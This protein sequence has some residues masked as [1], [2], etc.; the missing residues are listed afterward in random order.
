MT[1]LP[2]PELKRAMNNIPREALLAFTVRL[3]RYRKE[4]KELLSYLL[5][6]ADDQPGYISN[7]K[8]EIERGFLDLN[9]A[10]PY[11]ALKGIRKVMA[12]TNQRIRFS[13]QKRTEAELLICFCTNLKPMVLSRSNNSIS[14]IYKR[15]MIRIKRTI[16]LLHEDLQ[17]DYRE[18]VKLL[19]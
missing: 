14:S 16:G 6:E 15:Q 19:E 12:F 9:R 8:S 7:V 11:L 4:N 1:I 17:F 5:F 18:E 3:A 2:L 13:G 10:S